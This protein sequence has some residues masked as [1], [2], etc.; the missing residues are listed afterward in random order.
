MN[1][2]RFTVYDM[3]LGSAEV[4]GDRPALI[5]G[6][7]TISYAQLRDRVKALALGL[8]ERGMGPGA[9][10]CV[11]AQ[12]SAAY[13]ELY[14]ACAKLGAV[15]HPVNWRL[16]P[17]EIGLVVDRAKPTLM[18]V[19]EFTQGLVKD[20]PATRKKVSHWFQ[21]DGAP[22]SGFSDFN[23]LYHQHPPSTHYEDEARDAGVSA[24][25]AFVVIAT[26]AVDV[27][28]R[29]AVLTHAN[30]LWSALMMISAKTLDEKE[31][32]LVTL[33]LFHI[34]ALGSSLAFMMAGG[35]NVL[36]PKFDADEAVRLTDAHGVTH[37]SDFPPVL[38]NTLNSAEKAGSRLAS[39]KHVS[40][41]DAPDTI[42]KL[43]S[44][45]N[46]R[47][48]TGFGQ[49]ET[50]GWVTYQ[51]ATEKPGAS[52]K[53]LPTCRVRLVNDFDQPMPIGQAGEIVVRGP[54]VF[55]GYHAQPEETEFTFRGGWHHT[56]DVGR[57][58]EEGYLYFVGR[59]PEKELIKPGGENVYPAEVEKVIMEIEEITAV[60]VFGVKDAQWGEAV[61]AVV[62][63]PREIDEQKVVDHVGSRIA[64]FKRP[65]RVFF[66]EKLPLLDSGEVDRGAVKNQWGEAE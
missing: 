54:V 47:F 7:R 6:E 55:Q 37:F 27:V 8:A 56:G 15:V 11:L 41:L 5:E 31:V 38:S 4:F 30:V 23:S 39:L 16:S 29:G 53:P 35:A 36:M 25:D 21:L 66:T 33:P 43:E 18:V 50:S 20:W 26:A 44:S 40:G 61:R 42:H 10:M 52:G 22:A 62:E 49:S 14:L 9:H 17:D 12:N 3:F 13:V 46:A 1:L 59:K 60:C 63:S 32:N 58:D 19:D 45:T 24:E 34:A 28:P 57:M 48:W 65:K 64:R 51:R 2:Q